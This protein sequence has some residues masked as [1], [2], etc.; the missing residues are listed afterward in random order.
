M[1]TTVFG[2]ALALFTLMYFPAGSFAQSSKPSGQSANTTGMSSST[3]IRQLEEYYF[4][5]SA[6][7]PINNYPTETRQ[8]V[9]DLKNRSDVSRIPS[10]GQFGV[11]WPLSNRQTIIGG[12]IGASGDMFSQKDASLDLIVFQMGASVQHFFTSTIGDGAFVRG[13]VGF[14]GASLTEQ[15]NNKT[16]TTSGHIGLAVTGGAGYAF[17]LSAGT[18]LSIDINASYRRLPGYEPG[19][20]TSDDFFEKGDYTAVVFGASLLW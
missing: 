13:D 9:D 6:G 14:A 17:P 3:S 7:Y 2:L 16:T 12:V 1:K 19:K 8:A 10:S 18:S 15:V 4:Y 11:Y 20:S 5:F